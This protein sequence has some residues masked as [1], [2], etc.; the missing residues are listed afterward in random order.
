MHKNQSPNLAQV[1]VLSPS[2]TTSRNGG[3]TLE[4]KDDSL[5][6]MP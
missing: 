3:L 4:K 2:P 5:R 6:G 1:P